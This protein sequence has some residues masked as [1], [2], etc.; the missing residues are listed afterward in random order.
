MLFVF[1]EG[2]FPVGKS[3]LAEIEEKYG[4]KTNDRFKITGPGDSVWG[5]D[6]AGSVIAELRERYE[7][8]RREDERYETD[9]K[10]IDTEEKLLDAEKKTIEEKKNTKKVI[11]C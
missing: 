5:Y 3:A 6:N 4:L 9:K 8:K 10:S 2:F 11:S 7:Q 1:A